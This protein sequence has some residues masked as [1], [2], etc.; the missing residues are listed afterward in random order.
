MLHGYNYTMKSKL[1]DVFFRSLNPIV[2][3]VKTYNKRRLVIIYYHRVVSKDEIGNLLNKNM[4][5]ETGSFESQMKFLA[6][7]YTPV[8]ESEILST[9]E[10]KKALPAHPAWVTFDDG[11]K[12]NFIHAVPVL[13]KYNIFA[14]FFITTGFINQSVCPKEETNL[15]YQK[16]FMPW[17]NIKNLS[18]NGFGIGCHTVNHNLLSG[19]SEN[20]ISAEIRNSQKEMEGKIGKPVYSFSYPHGKPRDCA[21]QLSIPIL[22]ECGFRLA[23]TTVGGTNCLKI[24]NDELFKLRRFGISHDDSLDVFKTKVAT[25]GVWQR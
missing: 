4:C 25:G 13:K 8:S 3:L 9:L 5:T 15:N 21:F 16:L 22:K 2:P 17:D 14:T 24:L 12:D 7:Q 19:L 10:G 6:E 18:E 11:Y 23:V 1:K 20:E